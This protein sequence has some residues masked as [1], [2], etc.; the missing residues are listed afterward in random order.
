MTVL[1]GTAS[2]SPIIWIIATIVVGAMVFFFRSR[3]Q[4]KYKKD[5]DQAKI[6]L[7]GEEVPEPEYRHVKAHNIYWG[8]FWKVL[9]DII[10]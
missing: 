2:W 3:G 9:K 4:K 8:F 1:F 10:R 6:F 5:T 7:C